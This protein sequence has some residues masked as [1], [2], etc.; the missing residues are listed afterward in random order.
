M[1]TKK[2]APAVVAITLAQIVAATVA[3]ADGFMYTPASIHAPLVSAGLVEVNA[4]MVDATG[5]IA[6]RATQKG[7][8]TVNPAATPAT[9]AAPA[10]SEFKVDSGLAI[11]SPVGRGRTGEKFPFEQMQV[12]Q[13]FFVPNSA[14]RE[15]AA[16]SLASTIS[17]AQ[18]RYSVPKVPAETETVT[19]NVYQKDAA[20][21]PVKG[22]DGKQ[23]KIGETTEVRPVMVKT[24]TFTVRTWKEGE[25]EGAR[26]WRTA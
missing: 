1:A 6:T 15:N 14:E 23:I 4:A 2:S 5:A 8:E 3:S 26:V 12:G 21:K 20:G 13:S 10:A 22:A 16:K 17:A 19:V 25:V 7:V 9:P 18:A 24:R 11:P